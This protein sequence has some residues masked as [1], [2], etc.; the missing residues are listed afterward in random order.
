MVDSARVCE[1]QGCFH[2]VGA[3]T[4][5]KQQ[6]PLDKEEK[7]GG[8]AEHRIDKPSP[9]QKQIY[10]GDDPEERVPKAQPE[11]V[12]RK[13]TEPDRQRDDPEFQRRL[14]KKR[15]SLS[16]AWIT[17][18]CAARDGLRR[19]PVTA[20]ENAIHGVGVD[21]F[22]VV[23]ILQGQS[24]KQREPKQKQDGKDAKERPGLLASSYL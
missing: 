18:R 2:D 7:H 4:M 23:Q 17:G 24:V 10:E 21:G 9:D 8:Q 16:V 13:Q 14:L 15:E 20:F 19:Q 1:E 3:H 11:L 5:A 12:V 22:V 6:P